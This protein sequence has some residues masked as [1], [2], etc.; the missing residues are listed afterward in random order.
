MSGEEKNTRKISFNTLNYA[1]T[2]ESNYKD[3]NL[4][5]LKKIALCILKDIQEVK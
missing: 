5:K 1:V 2:V 3:D 4:E